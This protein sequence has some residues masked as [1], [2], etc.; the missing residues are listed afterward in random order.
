MKSENGRPLTSTSGLHTDVYTC[1]YTNIHVC[2]HKH[3][4]I[5]HT[6]REGEA[7]REVRREIL[8]EAGVVAYR[9]PGLITS[10][11]K[12]NKNSVRRGQKDLGRHPQ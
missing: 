1:T 8:S 10:T 5:T 7:E 9:S 4:H 11:T 3:E 6:Q 12:R 2:A